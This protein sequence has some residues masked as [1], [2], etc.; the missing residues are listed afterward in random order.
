M[1]LL[2]GGHPSVQPVNLIDTVGTIVIVEGAPRRSSAP[3][4][5]RGRSSPPREKPPA[6]FPAGGGT[7]YQPSPAV[8]VTGAPIVIV[9]D[10]IRRMKPDRAGP[11][12]IV[13]AGTKRV[14]LSI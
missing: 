3:G 10:A 1:V 9:T 7:G 13:Q 11:A 14:H 2:G 8:M 6:A 5:G 12:R 4:S